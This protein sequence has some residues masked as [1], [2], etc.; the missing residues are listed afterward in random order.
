[1]TDADATGIQ[2]TVKDLEK[3][4][5]RFS[6]ETKRQKVALETSNKNGGRKEEAAK[7]TAARVARK[8]QVPAP[9]LGLQENN[10]ASDDGS[11]YG[12]DDAVRDELDSPEEVA[13]R[14]AARPPALNSSYLPLPWKGRLGYVSFFFVIFAFLTTFLAHSAEHPEN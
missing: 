6:R 3:L 11:E 10:R 8:K 1:V 5:R 14:G 12:A 2:K 7:T 4:Q 9:A 13:E